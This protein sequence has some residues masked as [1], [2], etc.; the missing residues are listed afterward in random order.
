MKSCY[1]SSA[2]R[3]ALCLWAVAVIGAAPAVARQADPTAGR[4]V[5]IEP[6]NPPG[7]LRVK[8]GRGAQTADATVGMTVRRGHLLTLAADARAAVFCADGKTYDLKPG[9]SQGCPC[10]G[11]SRGFVYDG[12]TIPRTRGH[13]T[14]RGDFPAV[15]SPR[16]GL[17][18]TTR[19]AVRWSPV[20]SS[21]PGE[22]VTYRVIMRTE[23]GEQVWSRDGVRG[24]ELAYPADAPELVR[25]EVYKAVVQ[26]GRKSSTQEKTADLG[27]TV[28][29][30]T[31]AKA[32]REAET[33]VRLL[34][35]PGPQ[36]RLLVAD[37]YAAQGLS[38]EAVEAL[39]ELT[40]TLK[41]P[42]VLRLLGDLYAASGLHREA[43]KQYEEALALPQIGSDV[44]GQALTLA[45]LGRAYSALGDREQA[46]ARFARAVEA[47]KRLGEE[48]TAE[49]LRDGGPAPAAAP[50][51]AP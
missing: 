44:E 22:A 6:A 13:D 47:Y 33:A 46:T 49:Q 30:E 15:L 5:S 34:K 9:Q 18:L 38:S 50:A 29:T 17:L 51:K 25:G 42:A 40:K 11:A 16:K 7:K 37:L 21:K 45:A 26:S 28:L 14:A 27:F 2:A 48:V 8:Q 35:L 10:T 41:E 43:V 36:T 23:A 39:T 32:L 12:S 19:P 4:I 3:A 24:T 1:S 31:D 20:A